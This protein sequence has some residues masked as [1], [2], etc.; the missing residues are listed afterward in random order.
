[1]KK[2]L[3]LLSLFCSVITY[4]LMAQNAS[5]VWTELHMTHSDAWNLADSIQKYRTGVIVVKTTPNTKIELEQQKHEFWFGCALNSTAFDGK[6]D[7][8]DARV[9]KQ[10]FLE[11]FNAG[12]TASSLKWHHMEPEKGKVDFLTTDNI[13]TW[14]D[15]NHLPLRG[16]NLYWGIYYVQDWVKALTDDQ[17]Y[18]ELHKRAGS[19]AP[20]YKGRFAEYDF[21]NEMMH[22]DYYQE[23][24][25]P[26]ITKKRRRSVC[27][28]P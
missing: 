5:S 18:D 9:Y 8:Q 19:I 17:L 13:I 6:M 22:G 26:G 21:N 14:A 2:L 20:R 16:H 15:D 1:M 23:R 28:E 27:P 7:E 3:L 11:N 12:V 25:G 4:S 24:L 10:K